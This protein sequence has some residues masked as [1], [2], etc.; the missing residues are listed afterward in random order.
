MSTTN[1]SP[2]INSYTISKKKIIKLFNKNVRGKQFL[3]KHKCDGAEGMWLEKLMGI[4]PNSNNT[5]DIGGYEMKKSSSKI[6]FGDWSGEYLF[7]H[8]RNLI[9]NINNN[10]IVLSKKQFI[11]YFGNKS[12]VKENRYSWSGTCVPKYGHW[13]ECG[14]RLKIDKNNNICAFYYYKY[15]K[16]IHNIAMTI[17]HLLSSPICIAVWSAQKMSMH[18][19]NKF[20][21]KGFFICKQDKTGK[22]NNIC[23]GPPINYELFIEKIKS[24]DILFDSG[25]YHDDYY[26]N[27]RLYSH[28]RA[29]KKFW[30]SL[31]IEEY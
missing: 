8:N 4:Q 1:K 20:N 14:Q 30:N 12:T 13:N 2:I 16:R 27:N 15:D 24:N 17:T 6:S 26:P 28:W 3:D 7:S 22:Y 10:K 21:Q 29:S 5:P 11:M 25:M 9:D 23:F 18:V 31:I 19:N